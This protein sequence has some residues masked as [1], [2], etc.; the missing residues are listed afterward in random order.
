LRTFR[1]LAVTIAGAVVAIALTVG[2]AST[3]AAA[4]TASPEPIAA[5]SEQ[6]PQVTS[7]QLCLPPGDTIGLRTA[8]GGL[9][10]ATIG[11][12]VGLPFFIVGAVP[13]AIIVGLIG[14][15]IGAS[16]YAIDQGHLQAQRLC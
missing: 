5:A 12:I 10:G 4:P 14:A 9:L 13:G 15:M 7:I 3:A 11:G 1:K 8:L 6:P 2:F 16:S